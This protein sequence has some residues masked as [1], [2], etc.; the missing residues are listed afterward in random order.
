[1][2]EIKFQFFGNIKGK[3]FNKSSKRCV[4]LFYFV[5]ITIVLLI[6]FKLDFI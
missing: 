4:K 2:L 3:D 1:M 5:F 6:L